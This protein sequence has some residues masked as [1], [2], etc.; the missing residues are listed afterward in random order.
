MIRRCLH[1]QF[2]GFTG[3]HAGQL[4]VDILNEDAGDAA[5][6][7]RKLRILLPRDLRPGKGNGEVGNHAVLALHTTVFDRHQCPLL[8]AEVVHRLADVLFSQLDPGLLD[9]DA[10]EF[11]QFKRRPNLDLERV[12]QRSGRRQHNIIGLLKFRLADHFKLV[13]RDHI[14]KALTNKIVPHILANI[15]AIALFDQPLRCFAR[16]EPRQS[17]LEPQIPVV[18]VDLAA[19]ALGGDLDRH[20]LGRRTKIFDGCRVVEL[21]ACL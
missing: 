21:H 14:P 6:L 17:R 13:L 12:A 7:H 4:L 8:L 20:F 19:D 9:R 15:I 2:L 18:L 1:R 16:P 5:G 3:L 10:L 11:R